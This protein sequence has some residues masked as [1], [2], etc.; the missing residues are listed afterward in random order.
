MPKF[1]QEPVRVQ[2][3]HQ[4][5][6][7]RL[8]RQIVRGQLEVGARLP[9]EEE[10]TATYGIAR[11]TLREALRVLESQG[12]VTIR[13]G[14]GGGPVVTAPDAAP[15]AQALAVK[16]QLQGATVGDLDEAR[17]LLESQIAIRLAKDHTDDDLA[18]LR[19]VVA[20]ASDAAEANDPVAFGDAA[21]AFHRTLAERAWNTTMSM[22]S[23][24]LA[25][26][27]DT[28]YRAGAER[29]DQ[30]DMR[31]ACRS[32]GTFIDLIAAGDADGA[33]EHWRKLMSYTISGIGRDQPL[34]MYRAH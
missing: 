10:L 13:R 29:A 32:Y 24:L 2:K 5:V 15:L 19:K 25:Q 26:L 7:E 1:D 14:R 22:L 16:L 4:V 33:Q 6:A 21:A 9:P 34:D 20:D 18:A 31:R 28:Y 3:T 12:L 11:T 8:R 17:Q 23:L 30:R 27:V